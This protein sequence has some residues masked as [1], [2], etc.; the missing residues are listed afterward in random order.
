MMKIE[1]I[2]RKEIS[3]CFSL[4]DLVPLLITRSS[5]RLNE[6]ILIDKTKQQK[7]KREQKM[8]LLIYTKFV[9]LVSLTV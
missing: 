3:C 8:F 9:A 7:I 4:F 5:L 1:R 6:L 2:N